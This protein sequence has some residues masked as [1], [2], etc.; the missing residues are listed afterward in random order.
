MQTV[1]ARCSVAIFVALATEP[2]TKVHSIWRGKGK[3]RAMETP[4]R[5]GARN[6]SAPR[7]ETP[8]QHQDPLIEN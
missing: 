1:N 6:V 4:T 3:G 5:G 8:P 7:R 2:T